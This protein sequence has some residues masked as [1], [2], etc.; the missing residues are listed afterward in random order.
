MKLFKG[1]KKKEGKNKEALQEAIEV[2]SYSPHDFK[3]LDYSAGE[4]WDSFEENFEKICRESLEKIQ[5][6]E[7]NGAYMDPLIKTNMDLAIEGIF[8]QSNWHQ[9]LIKENIRKLHQGDEICERD[10]LKHYEEEYRELLATLQYDREVYYKNTPWEKF[11]TN[12]NRSENQNG[13]YSLENQEE[14]EVTDV[15]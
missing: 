14:K 5:P 6:D 3:P 13:L 8:I 2:P 9:L 12:V 7:F 1:L 4:N 11:Y 10:R 15:Q